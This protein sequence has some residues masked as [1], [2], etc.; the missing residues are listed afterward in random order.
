LTGKE[1]SNRYVGVDFLSNKSRNSPGNTTKNEKYKD[2]KERLRGLLIEEKIN[3][4]AVRANHATEMKSHTE[5]EMLLRQCVDD[6]REEISL[7][8]PRL[9]HSSVP[10]S[11]GPT[12]TAALPISLSCFQKCDRERTLELLLARERVIH[13]LST[14]IFPTGQHS[15]L[16]NECAVI[17]GNDCHTTQNTV[18]SDMLMTTGVPDPDSKSSSALQSD[19]YGEYDYIDISA[20]ELPADPVV[21]V[22]PNSAVGCAISDCTG[23]GTGTK[24]PEI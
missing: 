11:C 5:L 14:N 3:L 10:R 8:S 17:D 22:T 23:T 7:L 6:V 13:L 12:G 19:K 1:L 2:T 16:G 4:Q 18:Q 9:R 24:L 21:T 20:C 15:T